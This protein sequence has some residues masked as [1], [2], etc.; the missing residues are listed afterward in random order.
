MEDDLAKAG[1]D[2]KVRYPERFVD[3]G[4]II[5]TAGLSSGIDGALHLISKIA[6][7]GNAQ[8]VA[9]GMEYRWNPDGK[10]AR[11]G[12]ADRYLPDGLQYARPR[13]KGAEATMISTDGDGEHWETRILVSN[14]KTSTE[15]VDLVGT[16]IR[17]NTS[18]TRG[19]VALSGS[20]SPSQIKWTFT[21]D[22][23]LGWH[24][25]GSVEPAADDKGKFIATLRVARDKK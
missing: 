2:I 12:L 9:L 8:S 20:A 10:F 19:P 1:K 16:R 17:A 11:A 18:H 22:Q 14:P 24:G 6:G 15:I 21:D 3:A 7:N 5:T 13:L 25:V 4:K 23:G